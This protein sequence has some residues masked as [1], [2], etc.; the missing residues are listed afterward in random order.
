MRIYC[1]LL[2]ISVAVIEKFV[3]VSSYSDDGLVESFELPEKK[4]VLGIKWHPELMMT[5]VSTQRLFKRFVDE[6]ILK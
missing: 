1:N 3:K 2:W 4:F 5:D 6:C